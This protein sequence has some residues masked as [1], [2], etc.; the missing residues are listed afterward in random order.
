MNNPHHNAR[1]TVHS[2]ELIVARHRGVTIKA[3]SVSSVRS[4]LK[5]GL[6]RAFLEPEAEEL[7]LQHPNIRGH[8]YYH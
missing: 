6:D 5:T 2:R 4:V 1:T 3:R 8:N 7:P